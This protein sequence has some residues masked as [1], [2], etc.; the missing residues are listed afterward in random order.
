MSL[1][2]TRYLTL[3]PIL[4]P[5]KVRTLAIRSAC[6]LLLSGAAWLAGCQPAASTRSL[7]GP[8]TF[9]AAEWYSVRLAADSTLW[10]TNGHQAGEKLAPGLHLGWVQL[11]ARHRW[12][13]VAA[14]RTHALALMADGQLFAWGYN[15]TGELGT[16]ADTS[17]HARPQPIPG[18]YAQLAAGDGYSL[19]LKADGQLLGWGSNRQGQLSLAPAGGSRA[20][21]TRGLGRWQQVAAG[22]VHALGLDAAG[23]VWAWGRNDEGALGPGAP[24]DSA[25]HPAP[26]RVPLPGRCVQV[27]AGATCSLAL[28]ADGQLWTWGANVTGQPA[29]AGRRKPRSEWEQV[30]P[31]RQ[32][33]RVPGR[34][35]RVAAGAGLVLALDPAGQL[36]AWG[37]RSAG[38]LALP[39]NTDISVPAPVP[40]R[41]TQM[42]AGF[43]HC[44]ALGTDGHL[45]A[46]GANTA[47][48]T[49]TDFNMG[50]FEDRHNP[51]PTRSE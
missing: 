6:G 16:P 11:D 25:A 17:Y 21:P 41:Y 3:L 33:Q 26:V 9:A 39:D 8:G 42:A 35:A 34:W 24:L 12:V 38:R 23:Q 18:R 47:G 32:P 4:M 7:P 48:K 22:A 27:V 20:V 44:L 45:Y 2:P 51:V 15:G 30:P 36:W 49:G 29:A 13:R 43:D 19:A 5:V 46:W 37:H 50:A 28:L 10:C 40:G 1:T 14:G 31:L